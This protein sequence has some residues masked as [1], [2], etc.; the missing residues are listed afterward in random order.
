MLLLLVGAETN[1]V[2]KTW[3]VVVRVPLVRVTDDDSISSGLEPE[4]EPEL[5]PVSDPVLSLPEPSD[6][7]EP[8]SEPV[9]PVSL[10]PEELA[11]D[12]LPLPLLPVDPE[13][14]V[15]VSAGEDELV[16]APSAA[17]TGQ[18]VVVTAMIS[19]VTEPTRAGQSVMVAAQEVTV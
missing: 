11:S 4:L 14:V 15:P 17:V 2:L 9:L 6:A 3:V 16:E 5:E 18:M 13:L 10:E 12:P 7:A 8:D 1:T 19:V